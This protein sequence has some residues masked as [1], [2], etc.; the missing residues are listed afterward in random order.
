M[1]ALKQNILRLLTLK[2]PLAIFLLAFFGSAQALVSSESQGQKTPAAPPPINAVNNQPAPVAI[3]TPTPQSV[4]V[5]DLT[6][7]SPAQTRELMDKVQSLKPQQ[8][9]EL[10]KQVQN[11]TH[12]NDNTG[13]IEAVEPAHPSQAVA[14]ATPTMASAGSST[15]SVQTTEAERLE[16]NKE[17]M[18]FNTVVEDVLPMSPEQIMKLH[19]FYDLTLQAKATSPTAPPDPHFTSTVVSLEPGSTPPI[20]RLSAGFVT[21]V[22]FV[23]ST[24]SAWPISA[25]SIGDPQSFNVQWDQK[26]N[27]L[28]IQSMKQYS[29]GNLAIRLYNL[30]TPVMITLVS[31]QKN[32]D[33]RVDM[34]VAGRGPNAV[35]PVIETPYEVTANVNPLLINILDGIPPKGSIKLGIA[36]GTG[37]A[38]FYDHKIYFRSKLTV[39]SPAWTATTS[40]PDGTHVYELMQTPRILASQNGKTVD[41]KLSG[42]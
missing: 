36:G 25:Y 17:E 26:G 37:D 19:K 41:I 16:A 31:G 28:F 30:N 7:M 9:E 33:F 34:Q 24:G 38:W 13:L 20:V 29:H 14:T 22:V 8:I 10:S 2:H 23:D 32:V 4:Q 42:L 27:T 1:K 12:V 11:Q 3:A 6:K 18:A 5:Q 40:S 15:A 21:S 35:V 39:L